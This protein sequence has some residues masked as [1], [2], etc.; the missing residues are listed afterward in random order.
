MAM[1]LTKYDGLVGGLFWL[2]T[3]LLEVDCDIVWCGTSG[4]GIISIGAML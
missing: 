4:V 1:S 3:A 2:D